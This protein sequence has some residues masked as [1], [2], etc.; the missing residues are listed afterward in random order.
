MKPSPVAANPT[1]TQTETC[2]STA[3]FLK[4][5]GGK[6]WLLNWLTHRPETKNISKYYEPFLGGGS[7]FFNF[8]FNPALLSDINPELIN[9]YIQVRD[10]PTALIKELKTLK[11]NAETFYDLRSTLDADNLK[12]AVRFI[13]LNRTAFGGMYRVN[14]KGQYNVPFGNYKDTSTEI[15]WKNRVIEAAS[16]ALQGV[17]L[18][19]NDFE[20]TIALSTK[21]DLVFCDPTYTTMHDNNGF[22]KYN[23][24]SFTWA[25]QIRLAKCCKSA[26]ERG[27]TVIVSNACHS[28]I[29]ELYEGFDS[30]KLERHSVLCPMPSKR[31]PV[32]EY[33]FIGVPQQNI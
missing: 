18:D 5:L 7:V 4:W 1:E 28:D 20:K 23:E 24:P 14:S 33:L 9:T 26:L 15:L 21:N 8:A 2:I 17:D 11:V 27:A 10:N 31:K 25:D 32:H 29:R 3:P 19:C 6:R 12:R 13:Y 16:K 30:Y 22:R